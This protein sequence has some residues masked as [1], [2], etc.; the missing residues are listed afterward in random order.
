MSDRF[1]SKLDA[2]SLTNKTDISW[3]KDADL[4]TIQVA[5]VWKTHTLT[6]LCNCRSDAFCLSSD[7]LLDFPEAR[8]PLQQQ[9]GLNKISLH[10]WLPLCRLN[11]Y[12][13]ISKH[14]E[15]KIVPFNQA[16]MLNPS[17][18]K[19][20]RDLKTWRRKQSSPFG[21]RRIWLIQTVLG[22]FPSFF[23]LIVSDILSS[24]GQFFARFRPSGKT[25]REIS[26]LN[27]GYFSECATS[28]SCTEWVWRCIKVPVTVPFQQSNKSLR[29][30]S[31]KTII[32]T[33]LVSKRLIE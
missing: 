6:L 17:I 8:D 30:T 14:S 23:L 22:Y 21:I 16:A 31:S 2:F 3:Q 29:R 25:K 27:F 19:L 11:Y 24:G 32:S 26:F 33:S 28:V 18:R 13:L 5:S 7:I 15:W 4:C 9:T 20:K 1:G 12:N 10:H